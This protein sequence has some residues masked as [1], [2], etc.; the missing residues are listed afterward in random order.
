MAQGSVTE[1]SLPLPQAPDTRIYLRLSRQ[2]KATVLSLTTATPDH[3]SSPRPL[4]SFVYALPDR[5]SAHQPLATTLQAHEATLEFATRLAKLL[6]RKTQLPVYVSN[7]MS[8]ETAILGGSVQEEMAAFEA[9]V[10][11]VLQQLSAVDA[12]GNS[13][14]QDALLPPQ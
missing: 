10:D 13:S 11:V 8:F 12:K 14:G 6:A 4:G 5:S 3:V 7:S 2:A 9:I 1:L